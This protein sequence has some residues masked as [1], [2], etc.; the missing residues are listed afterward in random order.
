M[1]RGVGIGIILATFL[2]LCILTLGYKRAYESQLK[3]W[4]VDIAQKEVLIATLKSKELKLKAYLE[5]KPKISEKIITKYKIIKQKDES[6][7]SFKE[8]V[9]EILNAFYSHSPP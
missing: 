3:E 1:L 6:C 8:G 7:S 5:Q 2:S 4:N 9:H